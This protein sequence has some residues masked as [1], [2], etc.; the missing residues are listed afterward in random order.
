MILKIVM[1][2]IASIQGGMTQICQNYDDV[3]L[4]NCHSSDIIRGFQEV[5]S[6]GSDLEDYIDPENG[7]LNR[8]YNQRIIDNFEFDIL[9]K[10]T[11]YQ[12]LN[13]EL[14]RRIDVKINSISK[15]FVLALCQDEQ[16]HIAKFIVTAGCETDSDERL[17]PRE[18][19][20]VIDDNMICLEKLIDTEKRD[21]EL[22]LV[23]ANCIT[24]R[25]RER[26]IHSKPEDKAHELL[27]ILQRRRYKDFFN[28]MDCLRKTMQNNIVK[29]LKKGGVTEIK[30]QLFQERRDK[31]N[32]EAELIRKL[33]GYVDEDRAS[34]LSEDQKQ[35]V[36]ELLG[37]L[38]ENDIHFIGAYTGTSK[39]SFSMFLQGEKDDSLQVLNNGCE[40][41]SLKDKLENLFRSLLKI[42]DSEP[43]LV[44]EVTTGQH[45]NRHHVTTETELNSS[46]WIPSVLRFV[47]ISENSFRKNKDFSLRVL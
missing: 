1:F 38:A 9:T 20:K 37:E 32:I 21:L 2:H 31:R 4:K 42:P 11:S 23:T 43:P 16:D 45:S 47:N 46:K 6:R 26:L 8:L 27:I 14:L 39:G 34:D 35:F 13:G 22:K 17:L 28:F 25:H 41:G 36:D 33:T 18:W 30:V 10:I 44:K 3:D 5:Q 29:I 19:R 15:Q 24:S 12:K 40:S 7:L